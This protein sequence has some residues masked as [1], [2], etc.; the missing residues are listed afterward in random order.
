MKLH[1]TTAIGLALLFALG[2]IGRIE[3]SVHHFVVFLAALLCL[4]CF[5]AFLYL[6][7][8]A[9]RLL[10]PLTQGRGLILTLHHVR[11]AA[12]GE[13]RLVLP[14][15]HQGDRVGAGRPRRSRR[16]GRPGARRPGSAAGHGGGGGPRRRPG[17]RRAG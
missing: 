9:A 5:A 10:R 6:I 16:L 2:A 11:P 1:L 7:D 17:L 13:L 3:T 4:L 14:R 8:Y 12:A 15:L